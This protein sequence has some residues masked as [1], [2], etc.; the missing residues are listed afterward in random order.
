MPEND[1]ALLVAAL[2]QGVGLPG[3]SHHGPVASR[4]YSGSQRGAKPGGGAA[5]T[6]R[7]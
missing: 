6:R 2:D 3:N 5:G 1:T 7:P 4:S